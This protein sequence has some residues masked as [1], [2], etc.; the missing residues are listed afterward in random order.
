MSTEEVAASPE[1]A[2]P[3]PKPMFPRWLTFAVLPFTMALVVAMAVSAYLYQRA[4]NAASTPNP[5][6]QLMGLSDMPGAQAP[7]F[8]LT[9][10]HGRPIALSAFRGKAV[11]LAFMDSRCTEVCPVLAQEFRLAEQNLGSQASKVAFIGVNVDPMAESVADVEHFTRIH[12]LAGMKNW[13]FLT[14]PTSALKAVWKTYGIEV[15]VPKNAAQTVHADYLY[16][17]DPR[18]RER[19]LASPQVDQRKNGT[20]FL[21]Q[22][23]LTQ[24]GQGITTYLEKTLAR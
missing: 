1:P 13:Y 17:I 10:Q 20:G 22:G 16:F 5:L 23:Q 7:G 8:T 15:I 3:G 9:D 14:G 4:Q 19:Y 6:V 21:P 12:G 11:L 18:G 2:T 24:W